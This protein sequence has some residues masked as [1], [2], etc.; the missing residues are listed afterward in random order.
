MLSASRAIVPT[1]LVVDDEV[2]VRAALRMILDRDYRVLTAESGEAAL[3]ILRREEISAV[4]LDLRMP[5]WSGMETLLRIRD[6]APDVGVII[7]TAHGSETDAMRALR[8][9]ACDVVTKP[10]ET[11]EVLEAV[12]R[13]IARGDQRHRA[14]PARRAATIAPD[15]PPSL[16]RL[17]GHDAELGLLWAILDDGIQ[18]Y[19]REVLRG[20]TTSLDYRE[21]ER[22][23]FRGDAEAVTSFTNLCE[24]FGIDPSRMRAALRELRDQR[25]ETVVKRLMRAFG[26]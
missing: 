12:R 7:V 17:S 26:T 14:V 5:G 22:W 20:S 24:I 1:V 3:E 2:G 15:L 25:D 21:A 16:R 6:V 4:T 10:F 19:C 8:L 13:S 9:D 23:I 18:T 11:T